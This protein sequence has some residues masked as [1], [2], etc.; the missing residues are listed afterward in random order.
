MTLIVHIGTGKTGTTSVQA[1]LD[2]NNSKLNKKGINYPKTTNGEH[3]II[4][5]SVLDFERLHRVYRSRYSTNPSGIIKDGNAVCDDIKKSL[6][7]YNHT[8][9][10]GEYFLTFDIKTINAM[11]KKI[12][13]DRNEKIIVICY[14]RNP[15]SYWLSA[16]QQR[17]KGSA[18]VDNVLERKYPFKSGLENWI[19]VVGKENIIVRP[20]DRNQLLNGDVVSDFY[21]VIQEITA[22]QIN[23]PYLAEEK[24]KSVSAERCI[25][26]QELRQELI[27]SDDD[28]FTKESRL[29][30][31]I[32]NSNGN[33]LPQSRMKF[34]SHISSFIDDYHLDDIKWLQKE[35][36]VDL[37]CAK[38]P[39]KTEKDAAIKIFSRGRV[40]ELLS[41]YNEDILQKYRDLVVSR[42][43]E[44]NG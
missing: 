25:L 36:N 3:N 11:F 1:S 17:L 41:G 4:E 16:L 7:Q 22:V 14:V 6:N 43:H 33:N 42:F 13:Y 20:F 2:L 10:S 34:H 29:M 30:L 8:I 32:I 31:R 35:F 38:Q 24:N 19:D 44:L 12:G 26:M 18:T 28:T 21:H 23:N 40:R 37:P 15:S 5:G 9:I 27:S 39:T